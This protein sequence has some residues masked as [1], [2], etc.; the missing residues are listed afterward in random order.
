MSTQTD[1]TS[2]GLI[3]TKVLRAQITQ[4]YAKQSR[5]AAEEQWILENLPMV[6]HIAQKI[7]SYLSNQDDMEDLISAGTVGLVQAARAY[8]TDSDAEFRTYAYIR[9]R[10]A[11]IDEMRHKSFVPSAVH[12]QIRQI[13]QVYENL[14]AATGTPPDDAELANEVGLSLEQLY[15][16]LQTARKQQFLSING[17]SE[18]S[19]A[20][21]PM[22]ID[23]LP[24]PDAQIEQKETIELLAEAIKKLPKRDR[25]ILLLY[26]ERDLTMKEIAQVLE[27]TE[28]RVSQL[29]ASA[30]FKLSVKLG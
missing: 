12:K 21:G 22:I 20:S 11:I 25:T 7:A 10:G 19:P 6:R 26:Y 1:K 5:E 17:L 23:K 18:D 2:P 4:A 15:R 24:S 29:H 27:I 8:D 13:R 14:T 28:S 16:T 9:V 30:L 3:D